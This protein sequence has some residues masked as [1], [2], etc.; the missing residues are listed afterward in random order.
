M[1]HIALLRIIIAVIVIIIDTT[2]NDLCFAFECMQVASESTYVATMQTIRQVK[3]V[4]V[5]FIAFACCWSPYV[6]VLL[7]DYSDTLPLP[8][9]LY[10][11]MIAHLH[12][13]LNFVIYG[14]M[15]RNVCSG[16]ATY[17]LGCSY[18]QRVT[19]SSSD[20]SDALHVARRESRCNGRVYVNKS[21]PAVE[22]H[23]LQEIGGCNC[24]NVQ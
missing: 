8:V 18:C 19:L 24:R 13:S 11:S 12:A 21:L 16:S 15:N 7:Y 20:S 1:S 14:L 10:A 6:V 17:L 4:F 2:V 5:V 23:H 22:Y 3:T 9:H